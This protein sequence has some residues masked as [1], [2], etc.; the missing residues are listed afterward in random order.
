M[1]RRIF[2]LLS[3]FLSLPPSLKLI[4]LYLFV[5]WHCWLAS[6]FERSFNYINSHDTIGIG[7][8]VVHWLFS[9]SS[10]SSRDLSGMVIQHHNRIYSFAPHSEFNAFIYH[11]SILL[12]TWVWIELW[13]KRTWKFSW[14]LYV[15]WM[16]ECICIFVCLY[17]YIILYDL[18]YMYSCGFST[19]RVSSCMYVFDCLN[20]VLKR[21]FLSAN[22]GCFTATALLRII[23]FS[24]KIKV[25][26]SPQSSGLNY[27]LF[28]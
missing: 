11:S 26:G 16:N 17:L 8:N 6:L 14:N 1:G 10:L 7:A 15:K 27:K 9:R 13:P 12:L 5:L 2:F 22:E 3:L 28:T 24:P 19:L 23:Q 20:G 4:S 18:L 21:L 25:H